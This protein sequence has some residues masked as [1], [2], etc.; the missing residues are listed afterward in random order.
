MAK[1]NVLIGV[2]IVLIVL[3]GVLIYLQLQP[4]PPR[5]GN[6]GDQ[7]SVEPEFNRRGGPQTVPEDG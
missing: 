7:D 3:A 4:R 1:R 5:T 6:G 2:S